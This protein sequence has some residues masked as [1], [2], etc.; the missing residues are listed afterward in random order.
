M[1]QFSAAFRN[2]VGT[3]PNQH[4]LQRRVEH[5][6]GL[7]RDGTLSLA[8]I[9]ATVGFG[10]QSQFT[11]TFSRVAGISPGRYRARLPPAD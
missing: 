2:A 11:R 6:K 5:A 7:L 10:D 1:R 8:E 9:A 3:S 4:L